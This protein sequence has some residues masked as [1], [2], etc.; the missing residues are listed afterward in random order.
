MLPPDAEKIRDLLE[1]DGNSQRR[2]LTAGQPSVA[3]ERHY[4]WEVV[5]TIA[6]SGLYDS[7][8]TS[9]DELKYALLAARSTEEAMAQHVLARTDGL[10]RLA[11]LASRYCRHGGNDIRRVLN[12]DQL[13]SDCLASI[14]VSYEAALGTLDEWRSLSRPEIMTLR[15][16]KNIIGAVAPLIPHVSDS[17]LRGDINRW[18]EIRDQL[19]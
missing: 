16:A 15:E 12:P 18:L 11:H 1:M 13:A 8:P 9:P 14:E 2:W 17:E 19:P 5:T 10:I 4:W 7:V 6:L 3:G